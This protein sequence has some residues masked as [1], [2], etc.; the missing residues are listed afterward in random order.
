MNLIKP[1]F[2]SKWLPTMG[3]ITSKRDSNHSSGAYTKP[4]NPTLTSLVNI[5]QATQPFAANTHT[6][7]KTLFIVL[8]KSTEEPTSMNA[9][10]LFLAIQCLVYIYDP[11]G[12]GP[13]E[14]VLEG[15]SSDWRCDWLGEPRRPCE[16]DSWG[17][18]AQRFSGTE[19]S[20]TEGMGEA[21][22]A[23][24]ETAFAP[25]YGGIRNGKS[26]SHQEIKH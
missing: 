10:V 18:L 8:A 20:P 26:A 17:A 14:I 7:R 21:P 24:P 12:S 2:L 15:L 4:L 6:A 13:T 25:R 11:T 16:R 9:K 22:P 19:W 5:S 3:R 23:V 1:S